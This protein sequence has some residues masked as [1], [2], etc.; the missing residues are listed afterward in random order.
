[1]PQYIMQEFLQ[2]TPF[3]QN[4]FR[5]LVGMSTNGFGPGQAIISDSVYEKILEQVKRMTE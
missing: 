2:L 5:Q 3:Q 1:M 4:A